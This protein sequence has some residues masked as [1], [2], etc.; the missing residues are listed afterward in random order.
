[1]RAQVKRTQAGEQMHRTAE[2][3]HDAYTAGEFQQDRGEID[4]RERE[5]QARERREREQPTL[6]RMEAYATNQSGLE[7][8]QRVLYPMSELGDAYATV[9]SE[10]KRRE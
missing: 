9:A 4:F 6:G 3:Q 5:R 2:K 10:L 7:H 8:R 1:M